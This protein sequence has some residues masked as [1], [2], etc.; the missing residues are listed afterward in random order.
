LI[1]IGLPAYNSEPYIRRA[2]DS[3][4]AQDYDNFELIISDGASEDATLAICRGYAAND[5]RITV[6]ESDQRLWPLEN[7]QR[8]LNLA[9][10]PFFMWAAGGYRGQTL[11]T[12]YRQLTSSEDFGLCCARFVRVTVGR[13]GSAHPFQ[14]I[15]RQLPGPI[16]DK[17][18]GQALHQVYGLYRTERLRPIYDRVRRTGLVWFWDHL[19]ILYFLLNGALTGTN[20]TTIYQVKT[21]YSAGIFRPKSA[22]AKLGFTL[23]VLM[24]VFG[25]LQRARLTPAQRLRLIPEILR[26]AEMQVFRWRFTRL[27]RFLAGPAVALECRSGC[28][29]S[30][31]LHR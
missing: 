13:F 22:R 28:D 1:S 19:V 25:I 20:D 4:L 23:R 12:L 2:L 3:L 9:R 5:R 15:S 21:F 7:F 18:R 24:R 14:P 8:V 6:V 16:R 31:P 11:S 10:G 26:Y 17:C 30:A 29:P 27:G